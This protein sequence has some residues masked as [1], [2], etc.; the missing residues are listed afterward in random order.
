MPKKMRASV[1]IQKDGKILVMR[2]KYSSGR[3]MY[4]L[5]GG[6]VEAYETAEDAAI[7][8]VKEETDLDAEI[9]RLFLHS[10]YIDAERGKDVIEMVFEGKI[11]SGEEGIT[12]DNDPS[13]AHH[14]LGIEWKSLRELRE[15][16]FHPVEVLEKLERI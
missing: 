6:G 11:L 10:Y 12:N 3:I 1:L 13:G 4:L 7:R 9:G 15:E 8:E 2:S 5:P 14:I 16:E